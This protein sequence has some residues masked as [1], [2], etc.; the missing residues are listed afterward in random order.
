[1]LKANEEYELGGRWDERMKMHQ[2]CV[3]VLQVTG[4]ES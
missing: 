2:V 3:H 1:M 4:V